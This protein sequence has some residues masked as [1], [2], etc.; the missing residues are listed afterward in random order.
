MIL[1]MAVALALCAPALAQTGVREMVDELQ[2]DAAKEQRV[3]VLPETSKRFYLTVVYSYPRSERCQELEAFLKTSPSMQSLI[4]QVIFHD[5]DDTDRIVQTTAWKAFLGNERPA[6][7]LQA[8]PDGDGR[9]DVVYFNKG[10]SLP[11]GYKLVRQL[12]AA[13]DDY[14]PELEQR[15]PGGKCPTIRPRPTPAPAPSV[16]SA[17]DVNPE[18]PLKPTVPLEPETPVVPPEVVV[19]EEEPKEEGSYIPLLLLLFPAVA[20]GYGIYQAIQKE[21]VDQ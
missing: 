15:C 11:V 2:R 4:S 9:S 7:L 20:T 5:W 14:K 3:D 19:P 1:G 17:P 16:P 21:G 13:I 6:L 10:E 18:E 8:P 12:A